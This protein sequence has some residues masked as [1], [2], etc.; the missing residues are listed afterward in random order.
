MIAPRLLC[1]L[2]RRLPMVALFLTVSSIGWAGP[3]PPGGTVTNLRAV[4]TFGGATVIVTDANDGTPGD[5][6]L[7]LGGITFPGLLRFNDGVIQIDGDPAVQLFGFDSEN[8]SATANDSFTL[9]YGATFSYPPAPIT[10]TDSITGTLTGLQSSLTFQGTVNSASVAN[11]EEINGT[12]ATTSLA[13]T[14]TDG[15]VA[16]QTSGP[17]YDL[18]GTINVTLSPLGTV[19]IPTSEVR[20]VPEPATPLTLI[21]GLAVVAGFI[22]RRSRRPH[23]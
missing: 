21:A 3:I 9:T 12:F 8:L 20:I 23:T 2:T 5:G 10:A 11:P 4:I 22:H 7:Q 13:F 19:L 16:L 18:L 15:P 6:I 17:P 14:D 1:T